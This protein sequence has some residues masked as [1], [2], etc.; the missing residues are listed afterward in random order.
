MRVNGVS[1]NTVS[2]DSGGGQRNGP[3]RTVLGVWVIY[4]HMRVH[5]FSTKFHRETQVRA[6]ARRWKP[7][8]CAVRPPFAALACPLKGDLEGGNRAQGRGVVGGRKRSSRPVPRGGF[9]PPRGTTHSRAYRTDWVGGVVPSKCRHG[10]ARF[11]NGLGQPLL[12]TMAVRRLPTAD[13][14]AA[15][16]VGRGEGGGTSSGPTGYWGD[17]RTF[18]RPWARFRSHHAIPSFLQE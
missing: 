16:F 3:R 12:C 11:V 1:Q 4:A 14:W 17:A 8:K 5:A 7:S 15:R 18:Q 9:P 2:D 10:A 13:A 6:Y